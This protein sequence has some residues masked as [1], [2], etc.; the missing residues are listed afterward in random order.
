MKCIFVHIG[1]RICRWLHNG[2]SNMAVLEMALLTGFKPDF[3]SL[4]QLLQHRH[5]K[6]KKYE[7]DGRNVIFYF[8]EVKRRHLL[9]HFKESKTMDCY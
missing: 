1:H 8:D 3:D 9:N 4:E 2:S 6:L 7:Y 5:L